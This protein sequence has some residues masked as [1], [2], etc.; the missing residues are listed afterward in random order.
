MRKLYWQNLFLLVFVLCITSCGPFQA[1]LKIQEPRIGEVAWQNN[2]DSLPK[3]QEK[4]V[5]GVYRFRD[6]TGQYK[7]SEVGA[8]WSTAIPQGTTSILIK[9]LEDTNW[10]TPIE[11]EN[12]GNLLNERQIIRTTRSDYDKANQVDSKT[13]NIPPLL[14]AGVLLEGGVV[15][16]D[17]NIVTG[18]L[19]VRY[20]GIGGSTEYRQDRITVY[21]RAVSTSTGKILKTVYTS[22][23]ILSQAVS[24]SLFKYVEAERLL[25]SEVGFSRNEP[26]Q[27]AVT[28]AMEKAVYS[29]IVEGIK[30]NIWAVAPID[31]SKAEK[32]VSAYQQ[33][34]EANPSKVLAER[35]LKNRRGTWNVNANVESAAVRDDYKD[36]KVTLGGSFGAGYIFADRWNL[37][38]K[39][40][41][42][43]LENEDIFRKNF[44]SI[45]LNMSFIVF[46]Y[47]RITPFVYGGLGMI[48]RTND[49]FPSI[50]FKTQFGGGLEFMALQ[51]VGVKLNGE[52][53][54]GFNDNWDN[55][56]QG[57]RHDQ[58][59]KFGL[60]VNYYFGGNKNP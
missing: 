22:K 37:N 7:A 34:M 42:F 13:G 9:I 57:K 35:V 32:I 25:E 50:Q 31:Q 52:Y 47:D 45:D 36:P 23:T 19:G 55:L 10:F 58:M 29:L 2:F 1:P 54:I 27:L 4:I 3:P 43:N 17:T 11:R 12:I 6:Q 33:E 24:A 39:F 59:L 40:S 60:G 15:S 5:V 41:L 49:P 18:G 26:V 46:P 38:T 28:S 8:N 30:D 48:D 44:Y 53:N 51:N 56:V 21:L 20:F 16:Y 14:F